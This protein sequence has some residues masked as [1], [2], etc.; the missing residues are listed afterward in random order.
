M[1]RLPALA[2]ITTALLCATVARAG[3]DIATL[4]ADTRAKATPV[5]PK[6]AA[7]LK[8]ALDQRGPVGAIEACNLK[9]PKLLDQASADTG[10]QVR[11]V[12]LRTR[13]AQTGTPDAWQARQLADFNIRAAAGAKPESLEVGEIVTAHDGKQTFRYLRALPVME[14]CTTCHGDAA[15]L[16]PAVQSKLRELYPEDRATG[17]R[18]GEIRGALAV[19]RPL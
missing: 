2:L 15:K 19:E 14:V 17:Y 3:Q 8:E 11:R 9:A 7:T 10:W 13:N 4:T 12:S 1:R 18:V 16:D 6:V 5:L